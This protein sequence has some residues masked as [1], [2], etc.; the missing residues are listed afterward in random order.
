[1]GGHSKETNDT[2]VAQYDRANCNPTD[3]DEITAMVSTRKRN[4]KSLPVYEN[5]R[6]RGYG[7]DLKYLELKP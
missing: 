4:E 3:P 1:M 2:A 6:L 7:Q 5:S